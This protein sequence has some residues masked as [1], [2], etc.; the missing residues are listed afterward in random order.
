MQ[1]I[2]TS[3]ATPLTERPF[4]VASGPRYGEMQEERTS[5][6]DPNPPRELTTVDDSS[7]ADTRRCCNCGAG[8]VVTAP[9]VAVEYNLARTGQRPFDRIRPSQGLSRVPQF[10]RNV[11]AQRFTRGTR[12][13]PA[14]RR[15]PTRTGQGTVPGTGFD[16]SPKKRKNNI[17]AS[18]YGKRSGFLRA[19]HPLAK[20]SGD[21]GDLRAWGSITVVTGRRECKETCRPSPRPGPPRTYSLIIPTRY[22]APAK[23]HSARRPNDCLSLF[24]RASFRSLDDERRCH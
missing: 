11:V 16:T 8:A 13:L 20:S 15:R 1:T 4:L 6:D 3:S 10:I 5:L 2:A 24:R 12:S 21:G 19:A 23:W 9:S 22:A 18:I 17:S 14:Q 7:R